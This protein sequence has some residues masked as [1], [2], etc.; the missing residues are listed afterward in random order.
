MRN[1]DNVRKICTTNTPNMSKRIEIDG[2][3]FRVRRGELVQI[4]DEW[5]GQVIHPQTMRKRSSKMI[6]KRKR[7]NSFGS[8]S[9]FHACTEFK[10]KRDIPLE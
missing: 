1:A 3:F 8:R 4:P 2:K 7:D 5:V 6:N 9:K 10:D